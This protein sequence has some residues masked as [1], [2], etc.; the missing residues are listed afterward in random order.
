MFHYQVKKK[1][2]RIA[3]DRISLLENNQCY[4]NWK[5]STS[6]VDNYLQLLSY[7]S[8]FDAWLPQKNYHFKSALKDE[9]GK[10]K[11]RRLLIYF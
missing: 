10:L 4:I 3:I 5:V 11:F 9:G 6:I 2:R 7:V 1:R 8:H